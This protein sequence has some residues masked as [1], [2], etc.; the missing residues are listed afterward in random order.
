VFPQGRLFYIA[1]KGIS[2]TYQDFIEHLL[3]DGSSTLEQ[4]TILQ[5]A[6]AS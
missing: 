6:A 4:L 1:G 2:G 3:S 5:A